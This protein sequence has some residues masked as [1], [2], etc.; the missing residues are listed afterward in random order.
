MLPR[1]RSY[2]EQ[3]RQS[4]FQTGSET[5]NFLHRSFALRTFSLP[6]FL[7]GLDTGAPVENLREVYRRTRSESALHRMLPWT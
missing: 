3:A 1:L 4:R 5:Y 6:D 2:I 7:E